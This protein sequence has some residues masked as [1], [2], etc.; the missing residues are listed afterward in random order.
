MIE[1][2]FDYSKIKLTNKQAGQIKYQ[3]LNEFN[4]QNADCSKM[5]ILKY[6]NDHIDIEEIKEKQIIF[7]KPF[8]TND[9]VVFYSSNYSDYR[10]KEVIR[11]FNKK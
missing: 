11:R 4:K 10:I 7:I 8:K 3:T 1:I 5:S 2:V 6:I 9:K